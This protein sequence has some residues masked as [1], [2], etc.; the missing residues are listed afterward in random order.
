[1][2]PDTQGGG[3]AQLYASIIAIAVGVAIVIWRNRRPQ[4]LQMERLWVRPTLFALIIAASL[5]ASPAPLTAVSI[6]LFF[7]SMAVGAGLGWQ[8][9]RFMRIEVDPETHAVTS[10]ASVVGVV[11]IVVILAIRMVLRESA[12]QGRVSLGVPAIA[13]TDALL[14]LLGAMIITQNLEMWLRARGLLEA[15]RSAKS[16]VAN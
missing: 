12:L 10:R 14:L 1:M 4:K 7:I 3:A 8:R 9:G 5:A 15:A 6:G 13:I 11:F 2:G 16:T